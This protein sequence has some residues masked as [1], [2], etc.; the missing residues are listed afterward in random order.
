MKELTKASNLRVGNW[1]LHEDDKPMQVGTIGIHACTL[2]QEGV[3]ASCPIPHILGIPLTPEILEKC[4]FAKSISVGDLWLLRVNDTNFMLHPTGG[5][6][7]TWAYSIPC[8][9]LHQLQNLFFAI[10]GKELEVTL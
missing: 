8:E 2:V 9:Y 5:R 3:F 10:T 1:V 6:F 7:Y 4:G